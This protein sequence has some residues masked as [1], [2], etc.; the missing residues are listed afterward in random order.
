MSIL[1]FFKR[2]SLIYVYLIF[3]ST[4]LISCGGGETSNSDTDGDGLSDQEETTV[5][6]TSPLLADTDGDGFDDKQEIIEFGFSAATNNYKFNPLIADTP[7]ISVTIT[8]NPDIDLH[9]T[10]TDGV[11]ITR[12]TTNTVTDQSTLITTNASTNSTKV[13]DTHQAGGELGVDAKGTPSGKLSY[14]YTNVTTNE[15]VAGWTQTQID[16][17]KQVVT[18][19]EI[20]ENTHVIETSGGSIAY[21]ITIQNEGDIAFTLT[22]LTLSVLGIDPD[23]EER[24]KPIGN[25]DLDTSFSAFPAT[26]LGPGGSAQNLVFA[27]YNLDVNTT[28]ELLANSSGLVTEVAAYEVVDE[29]GRPYVHDETAIATRT[30]MVLIDYAPTSGRASEQYAIATNVDPAGSGITARQTMEDILIIPYTTAGGALTGIRDIEAA[31]ATNGQWVVVYVYDNG[32]DRVVELFDST[33]P[34][35]FDNIVLKA[36]QVLHLVHLND[37]DLD[38][39]SDRQEALYRSDPLLNDTDGD[40]AS[41]SD[42]EEVTAFSINVDGLPVE[43]RSNPTLIDSDGDGLTDVE[44]RRPPSTTT[45]PSDPQKVDT[46]ADGLDDGIDPFPAT[47]D[48]IDITALNITS[49]TSGTPTNTVVWSNPANLSGIVKGVL[50]LSY[51]QTDLSQ[52]IPEPDSAPVDGQIP[53]VDD[54]VGSNGWIVRNYSDYTSTSSTEFIHNLAPSFAGAYR[55]IAYINVDTDNDGIGD[56]YLR[57]DQSKTVAVNVA[58]TTVTVTIKGIDMVQCIDYWEL[59]SS[60]Q[61]NRCESYWNFSSN[62]GVVP[63]TLN[64]SEATPFNR[65]YLNIQPVSIGP[66][67][68]IIASIPRVNGQCMEVKARLYDSDDKVTNDS[69]GDERKLIT[70]RWCYRADLWETA[71]D[72]F[73]GSKTVALTGGTYNSWMQNSSGKRTN[74]RLRYSV[75]FTPNP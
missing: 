42:L 17:H 41:L 74:L 37:A 75:Q 21:S 22:S 72:T 47:T 18:E 50:W 59:I 70:L 45:E 66:T 55:Y 34:Y 20:V 49:V 38:G 63:E 67:G 8:S 3:I 27:N 28:K 53:A 5:H 73:H 52:S 40:S 15:S 29:N 61:D 30:A 58:T 65:L 9:Y 71:S 10:D 31:A 62:H 23:V 33:T 2:F 1:L 64:R 6:H 69:S 14:Q 68:V 39:L 12:G 13:S 7:K 25:L 19:S 44:E 36:G 16:D 60:I 11:S 43:V 51:E 48:I 46:D 54:P 32:P 24:F 57:S 4:L 56:I 26:S 35:D